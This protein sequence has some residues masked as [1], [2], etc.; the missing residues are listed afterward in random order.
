MREGLLWFDNDPKRSLTD[1]ITR[2]ATRYQSKFRQKPT[3]CFMNKADFAG[4]PEK[5]NGIV[6]RAAPNVLRHHLWIGVEGNASAR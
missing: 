4:K 6:L 1:K 2:A 5:V 3:I